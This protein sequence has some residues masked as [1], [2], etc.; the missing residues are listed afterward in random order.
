ME[1]SKLARKK[2]RKKFPPVKELRARISIRQQIS[3]FW[4]LFLCGKNNK[5]ES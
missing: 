3:D 1:L 4:D 2:L 5:K